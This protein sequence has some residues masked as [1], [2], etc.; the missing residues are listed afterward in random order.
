MPDTLRLLIDE[1]LDHRILRGLKLRLLGLD[2]VVAQAAGLRGVDDGA[3][4]SW[5][6]AHGRVLVTHDLKTIPRHAYERGEAGRPVPG[7]IA[8]PKD[9]P[10]GQAIE[11]MVIIIECCP[12]NE[13]EDVVFYLP[14]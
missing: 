6:A 3:L 1:N 7:I 8:I 14:L 4:L 5:A 12:E 9:L 11:E 2:Y 13:F 10:V